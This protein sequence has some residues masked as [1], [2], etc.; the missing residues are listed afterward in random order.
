ML[1]QWSADLKKGFSKK[2]H[3]EGWGIDPKKYPVARVREATV[4]R[5]PLLAS[6]GQ[7]APGIPSSYGELM[8]RESQV[9]ISTMVRL[10]TEHS[11]PSAPVH[12]SI[13]V[14]RSKVAVARRLL[15]EQFKD[16]IG[17]TPLLKVYPA[18]G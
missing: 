11:I 15:E 6:W 1:G 18:V 5:H 4:A 8:Y 3:T 13:L 12:D 2:Y 17:V 14:P 9:I 7:T 16:L 10:A